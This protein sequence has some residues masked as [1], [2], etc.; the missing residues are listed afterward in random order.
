M[1]N[2]TEGMETM[3]NHPPMDPYN[4]ILNSNPLEL[5]KIHS[6]QQKDEALLKALNDDSHFS[7]IQV[8]KGKLI[9]YGSP[10]S[11]MKAIAIPQILQYPAVRWL[12]SIL[13]QRYGQVPPKNI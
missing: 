10:G 8:N 1:L 7:I 13:G 6:Y 12:H 2:T 4:P 9:A 11:K 3:L 5:S